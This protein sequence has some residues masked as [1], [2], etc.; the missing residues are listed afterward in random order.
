MALAVNKYDN[1]IVGAV[2]GG[3][4]PSVCVLRNVAVIAKYV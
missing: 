4:H 2:D 3:G 1:A